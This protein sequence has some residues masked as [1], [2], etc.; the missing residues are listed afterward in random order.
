MARRQGT[1]SFVALGLSSQ[2][3]QRAF[4]H[5]S[6]HS[7]ERK[8]THGPKDHYKD[9][10]PSPKRKTRM[11]PKDKQWE[12]QVTSLLG[13]KKTNS[14]KTWYPPYYSHSSS[15]GSASS[16]FLSELSSSSSSTMSI[17]A[18]SS[19]VGCVCTWI[20]DQPRECHNNGWCALNMYVG[21]TKSGSKFRHI[22]FDVG[23]RALRPT[24]Q[25][26]CG[27]TP[28]P[29]SPSS[30]LFPFPVEKHPTV[31]ISTQTHPQGD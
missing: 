11:G 26:T 27:D 18:S 16:P 17:L 10:D 2:G 22:S 3:D 7:P 1:K 8:A 14:G 31:P 24:F 12:I 25:G 20:L 6:Q 9:P 30:P 23:V 28:L 19:S 13:A 15:W 29:L 4:C 21:C 5:P